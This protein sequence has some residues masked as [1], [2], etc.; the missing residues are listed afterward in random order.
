MC[1]FYAGPGVRFGLALRKQPPRH[2]YGQCR[3]CPQLHP[4]NLN[5]ARSY[6][7]AHAIGDRLAEKSQRPPTA[8]IQCEIPVHHARPGKRRLASAKE[9]CGRAP[10]RKA[11][12]SWGTRPH[13]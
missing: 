12:A 8:N 3:T 13:R 4:I 11:S 9:V 1:A 10:I 2:S 7:K 5:A 6:E